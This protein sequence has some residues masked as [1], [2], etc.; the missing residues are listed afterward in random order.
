MKKLHLNKK[1]FVIFG[2]LLIALGI[3][4]SAP[5]IYYHLTNS[6]SVAAHG[7]PH[8]VAVKPN[9]KTT[10]I[11]GHPTAISI[12]S[13]NINLQIIDG[14]Y[15]SGSGAWTLTLDKAQFATVTSE[16]NNVSGNTFIY[17]H[18][19]PE[20]FAYLHLIKPGSQ[21]IVTTDNGYKFYYKFTQT[22]ATSPQDGSVFTYEGTPM[23]T[24]QTCSGAW[25]Q[26]RQMFLFDYVSYKKTKTSA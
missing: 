14:F 21:A 2:T 11:K 4:G 26:N 8:S 7:L 10:L 6:G 23:L 3:I 5:T 13:L 1:F 12:P 17:G 18:Y 9:P 24:V 16:P 25:F 19:R 15:N 22:Y 20:V